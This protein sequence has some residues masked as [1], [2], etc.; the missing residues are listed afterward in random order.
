MRTTVTIPDGVLGD[1]MRFTGASTKTEAVNRAVFEWVR[2][3]RIRQLKELRG[4]L[5]VEGN[6]DALRE[7]E[8][9]EMDDLGR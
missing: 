1:L 6:A 2:R 8:K 5:P 4:A 9:A 3:E 7:L